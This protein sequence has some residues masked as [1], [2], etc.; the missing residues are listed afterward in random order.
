MRTSSADEFFAS[1]GI[2]KK[3][4]RTAKKNR[5]NLASHSFYAPKAQA[6]LASVRRSFLRMK[7]DYPQERFQGVAFQLAAIEP[8]ISRLVEIFPSAPAEMLRL[9]DE[10]SFKADSD[11]SAELD[12]EQA[13][14][15]LSTEAPFLPEDLIDDRHG[16]L[17]KV[18]W[19]ANRNYDAACYNSCAAMIRRLVESLIIEAFERHNR[20]DRIKRDGDYLPFGDLIGQAANETALRLSREGKRVLPD[21]KFLGDVGAHNRMA[22]VRKADLDRLHN[23]TRLAVEEL[24]QNL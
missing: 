7:R 13:T 14:P 18:L 21:L 8:L 4:L 19:E 20:A 16:V 12:D 23:Q 6:S 17:K 2:L 15:V 1:L 11:L 3:I 10:I 24:A 22:L 5:L 9:L